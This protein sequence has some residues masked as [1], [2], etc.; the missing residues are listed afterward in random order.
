M[1]SVELLD[2]FRQRAA[3]E[4]ETPFV[5]WQQGWDWHWWSWSRVAQL[6]ARW[7]PVLAALP[8]GARIGF[9]GDVWPE[10]LAVDLAVQAAGLEPVPLAVGRTAPPAPLTGEPAEAPAPPV[11]A[12]LEVTGHGTGRARWDGDLDLQAALRRGEASAVPPA[13]RIDSAVNAGGAA[14]P[15]TSTA[16]AVS[17][18]AGLPGPAQPCPAGAVWVHGAGWHRCSSAQLA[19]AAGRMARAA[20][21]APEA[22]PQHA[23]RPAA[24]ATAEAP[25]G[26]REAPELKSVLSRA[27]KSEAVPRQ[28]PESEAVPRQAPQRQI[29]VAG[30]SLGHLAGRLMAAWATVAGA[31]LVVDADPSRRLSA[32]LWARPTAVFAGAGELAWLRQAADAEGRQGRLRRWLAPVRPGLPRPPLGRLRTLFQALPPAPEDVAFWR[33]R[34]ARLLQL[35]S[36]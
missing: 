25:A 6:V 26:W 33:E 18:A 12:W 14:P 29:V 32:V 11:A 30:M 17:A 10:A 16:S 36:V 5:F 35:P 31:A 3:A 34:G 13:F 20:W 21:P 15:E 7:Q 23:T 28:A 9:A 27:P 4:P 19:A 22:A 24:H 1:R 8:C 2:A